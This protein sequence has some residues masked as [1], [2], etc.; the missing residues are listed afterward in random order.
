MYVHGQCWPHRSVHRSS[1][2]NRNAPGKNRP[3]YDVDDQ[4]QTEQDKPRG[5]GLAMPIIVRSDR[6]SKDHNRQG[7]R[8]LF[9][10][11]APELIAK[12][13]KQERC[14]FPRDS[15]E[16]Q[17]NGGEDATIRGRDDD[18][19]DGF[20][21]AGAQSHGGFAQSVRNRAQKFFGTAE[22]DGNHHQAESESAGECGVVLERVNDKAV[23]KNTDDDGGHAVEQVRSIAD[24]KSDGTAAKFRKIDGAKESDGN[25]HERSE[26]EQLGAAENGVG[27]AATGLADGR[28]QLSEKIPIN[29]SATMINEVSEN[30]EEHGNGN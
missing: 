20:P 13:G 11:R 17:Q 10:A 22:S 4:N 18:G 30:E 3:G 29:G 21:L 1:P 8:G 2:R 5:P 15:G 23:S 12:R 7:S 25:T 27:Q 28:W 19:G 26:Q 14:G 16:G 6:I 24:N 9:P